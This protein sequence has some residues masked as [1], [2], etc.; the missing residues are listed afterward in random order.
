MFE[1][2]DFPFDRISGKFSSVLLINGFV[3]FALNVSKYHLYVLCSFVLII[4]FIIFTLFLDFQCDPYF[5]HECYD[6]DTWWICQGCSL[7]G[8]ICGIFW[9]SDNNLAGSYH[10]RCASFFFVFH[11]STLSSHDITSYFC[12]YTDN[13]SLDCRIFD[14]VVR[15][16]CL[17]GL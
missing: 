6:V 8:I 15:Y 9:I 16:Q 11:H 5:H 2:D 3:A 10:Q 7:G 17:Q 13:I 1:A 12:F 14:F 4:I